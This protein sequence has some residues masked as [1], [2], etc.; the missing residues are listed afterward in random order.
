MLF[1]GHNTVLLSEHLVLFNI[2]RYNNKERRYNVQ[3]MADW[4][5]QCQSEWDLASAASPSSGHGQTS[6]AENI[7]GPLTN[8]VH[9]P[10]A[11][12]ICRFLRALIVPS[13]V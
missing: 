9:C 6:S 13:G 3:I 1:G 11:L 7:L 12:S 8:L 5:A 2:M 10:T 4:D